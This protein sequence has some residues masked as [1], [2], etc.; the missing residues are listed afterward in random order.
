MV[1]AQQELT[2]QT[3]PP[4]QPL[5]A[6]EP[7][8]RRFTL[9]EFADICHS[10]PDERLELINGEI[11]MSPPPDFIH[12]E[13][14]MSIE[15]LLAKHWAEIEKLGCRIA[16]SSAWY[17]VPHE[18]KEAWVNAGVKGPH[19]VCPDASVCFAD[20]LRSER[21]PPA[22]LVIEVISVSKRSEIERD[23]VS[24]PDIY[25]ALE[26]PA[27]WVIDRRDQSVW[28]HTAPAK[29]SK[30]RS[31]TEI[32]KGSMRTASTG[33]RSTAGRVSIRGREMTTSL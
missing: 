21:R 4:A 2:K 17:V 18:L 9:D 7:L 31:Y 19:H 22:L 11:V 15:H 23:L 12:I 5:I 26:I 20:Y 8:V 33:N 32:R 30:G 25:A 27:Y 3:A 14:T 1:A 29:L 6:P 16:G 24:K 13:Q 10:L 28:V